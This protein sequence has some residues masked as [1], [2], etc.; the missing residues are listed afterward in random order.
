MVALVLAAVSG[1]AGS[2]AGATP[3]GGAGGLAGPATPSPTAS[4]PTVLPSLSPTPAPTPMSAAAA[5]APCLAGTSSGPFLGTDGKNITCAGQPLILTGF[6]FYPAVLGG[7]KAW[8]DPSFP[9]Y[10][11]HILDM[12]AAAGQNLIRATDQ[13]DSTTPGQTADD[14]TVWA[15]MD[16]L[17]TAARKRGVFVVI[18]LSA[19]RWLLESQGTDPSRA[20]LWTSFIDM[21][22][23]RYRDNPD[24]AF[25]SIS[26]EPAPPATQ[27]QLQALLTFYRTT[28]DALRSADPNHLI[29]VGGFNHMEDHP[30]IG[31]WQSIDALP[32]NDIVAVKTYS[33]HDL[34]LMP[35]IAAY[36]RSVGKPVV[37]EEFGMPQGFGD[38]SFAG[39]AAYN[40]LSTGR[41]PFFESVYRSGRSLGFAAYIF[42]N[43]GCQI[44]RTSYEV[45]PATPATW[46]VVIQNGAVAAAGSNASASSLC[47]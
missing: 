12:G 3:S 14:P 18:D 21:V 26:G 38:G 19:F 15:N 16:Y 22:A 37:D 8:H 25:Y 28:S 5:A 29:T 46:S 13:W 7:A 42:W 34:D 43:M 36:G 41:A 9:A 35:A 40:G 11:D 30:E 20:D 47:P 6:T 44:G 45:S 4:T 1:C 17:L 32:A 10:I 23:A 39:G 27:A 24:V 33:Q 31:W 2:A